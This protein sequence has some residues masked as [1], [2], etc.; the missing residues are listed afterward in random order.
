MKDCILDYDSKILPLPEEDFS[1]EDILYVDFY[2]F[3]NKEYLVYITRM[4]WIIFWDFIQGR[5]LKK[6]FYKLF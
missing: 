3:E 2:I 4:N 6:I 5:Y 1:E